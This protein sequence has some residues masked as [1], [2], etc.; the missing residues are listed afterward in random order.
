MRS[1]NMEVTQIFS[2]GLLIDVV[3]RVLMSVIGRYLTCN[4]QSLPRSVV[5]TCNVQVMALG[6][7]M[8]VQI[9]LTYLKYLN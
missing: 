7:N 8:N 4:G 2:I 9:R 5:S 1:L 3:G 6:S